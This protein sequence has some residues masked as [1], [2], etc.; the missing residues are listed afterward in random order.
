MSSTYDRSEPVQSD[1]HPEIQ[2]M[3]G[4]LTQELIDREISRID[5]MSQMANVL[6]QRL[7]FGALRR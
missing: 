3:A 4:N 6:E 7:G 2:A 5:V 1:F